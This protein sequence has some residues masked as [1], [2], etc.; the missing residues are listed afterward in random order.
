MPVMVS[1][2]MK[3]SVLVFLFSFFSFTVFSQQ[4]ISAVKNLPVGSVVT[5]TGTI[6]TG[7][8]YGVIRYMQDANAGIALYS[9]S[10]SSTKPGDSIIVTGKLST[11]K[12]ELQISPVMSFQVIGSGKLLPVAVSDNLFAI[13]QQ[14]YSG[15]LMSVTC[16]AIN[17]CESKFAEGPYIAY[18]QFGHTAKVILNSES[19]LI[20]Q[21]IPSTALVISGIWTSLNDQ[22]QLL[23]RETADASEGSCLLIPPATMSFDNDL[24]RLTWHDMPIA[25]TYFEWGQDNFNNQLGVGLV[26]P[27]WSFPLPAL[28]PGK[29]YEG[30]LR[31]IHNG[32]DTIYSPSV[33]FSAPAVGP[34]IQVFF[35]HMVDA[36]FSDGSTPSGTLPSSI[37]TNVISL[38]NQVSQTLDIAV[39][40][41]GS[42]Y[43]I[44]AIK[45]AV[46]RGVQVR[47]ITDDE[48]SNSVLD[49][50]TSFPILYRNGD[51]IMH[52]KFMIGDADDPNS[53]W[54]W[55][56]STNW[57]IG[58]LTSDANHAY[59]IMDQALALNYRR[60][61]EEMW[62]SSLAHTDSRIGD[63]KTD[64]TAHD[65][66][67]NNIYIESYFSPSDEPDC[68]ILNAISSAD[69]S[70]EIGLL[71]LTS[72][73]L[74][75]EIIALHQQGVDVRV[76]LEDES[77]S[78][79]AVSRL[80]AEGVPLAIHDPSPLFHHKY[81]IIDEGHTDSDPMVVTGSHNWTFSADHI[82]DENTLIVHDQSFTNIFRQEFE[83]WWKALFISAVHDN[84][85]Q[86][87][88]VFPNPAH[89]G[90]QFINPFDEACDL[91]LLDINGKPVQQFHVEANQTSQCR[92]V[93]TLPSGYYVIKI[94]WPDHHA[95]TSLMIQ[96]N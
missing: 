83:Q 17:T 76:I 22:Y 84:Q 41:A 18:D 47:Y 20:G 14:E 85:A 24:V 53:A 28:E 35:N 93:H 50:I 46:Q 79:Y 25:S 33:L 96:S 34:P 65:F 44:D 66:S 43:I 21:S 80:R 67:F 40:N 92:F 19:T 3:L 13:Q 11:Y 37:E 58:Q 95:V 89:A 49:G 52:N 69:Y 87:L 7:T 82:N 1:W 2:K 32:T 10:L 73:T 51:G 91:T 16:V 57:T 71:L 54:L 15:R 8:E 29:I 55:T 63:A 77:S 70:I 27:D 81:A 68:H 72:E 88:L 12:G 75:N 78:T 86:S 23:V 59:V 48:T 61:F 62:G 64:N 74:I 90:F 36:T 4:T 45:K 30:R 56:G 60:E 42:T 5:T 26:G 94:K 9:S 39:Y 38:I 31:Q 6:S